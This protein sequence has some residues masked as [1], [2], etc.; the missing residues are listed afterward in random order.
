MDE[1]EYRCNDCG[2]YFED[3]PGDAQCPH[4]GSDDTV[5]TA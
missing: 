3:A 4:C 2:D 1:I 5:P